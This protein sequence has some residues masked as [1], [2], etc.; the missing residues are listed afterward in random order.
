MDGLVRRLRRLGYRSLYHRTS[1]LRSNRDTNTPTWLPWVFSMARAK[2]SRCAPRLSS[3]TFGPLG[4]IAVRSSGPE[5]VPWL[6]NAPSDG[7]VGHRMLGLAAPLPLATGIGA[8]ELQSTWG[9]N[10]VFRHQSDSQSAWTQQRKLLDGVRRAVWCVHD[11]LNP[12][13]D[14]VTRIGPLQGIRIRQSVMHTLV[15]SLASA[16]W[17]SAIR[18]ATSLE[19][20]PFKTTRPRVWAAASARSTNNPSS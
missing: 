18:P 3:A 14:S 7:N 1:S 12:T 15:C 13:L 5:A 4:A 8:G 9:F 20:T 2:P 10:L 6:G 17:L 16:Q 19:T 11:H